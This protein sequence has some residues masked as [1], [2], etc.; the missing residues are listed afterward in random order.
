M[1]KADGKGFVTQSGDPRLR[2]DN[3]I[4]LPAGQQAAR[5]VSAMRIAGKQH[6]LD[7]AQKRLHNLLE[8]EPPDRLGHSPPPPEV[9]PIQVRHP[10]IVKPMVPKEDYPRQKT[11]QQQVSTKGKPHHDD[12]QIVEENLADGFASRLRALDGVVMEQRLSLAETEK[13]VLR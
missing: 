9:L 2:K 11:S 4:R 5:T 1:G 8:R 3:G 7:D 13:N 10:E 6:L 12:Q